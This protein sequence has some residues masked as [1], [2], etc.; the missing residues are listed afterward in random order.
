[1]RTRYFLVLFCLLLPFGGW[2]QSE[3]TLAGTVQTESGTALAGATVLLKGSTLGGST[4]QEGR[5]IVKVP[6]FPAVVLVSFVG[7]QT[8]E[9][10]LNQPDNNL[11]V[12][13][14][15]TSALNQIVV[16]ASREAETIGRAPATVEKVDQRQLGQVPD[17]DLVAGLARFKGLDL[18]SSSMLAA[19]F[20][21]RGFNSPKSERVIQLADY[22]DTQLPSLGINFGNLNGL[23][24][25][26]VASVEIL[27]GP[28]SALYGANA[29]NGVLITNSRDALTDPGLTVRL[30]GGSRNLL[31]GQLRYA[32][33][34]G[35][36]LAFKI[37]GG[38]FQA[39]DFLPDNQQATSTLI[40]PDNNPAG[41]N[42]GFDAVNRYG[43]LGNQFT[44]APLVPGGPPNRLAGKTVF[45]PGYSETELVAGDNKA[46]SLKIMPSL[47]YQLSNS[48]KATLDYR[49]ASTT[50]TYQAGSRYRFLNS[51]IQQQRLR[52]EG[53]GWFL[54]AFSTQD[55]SG[56]RDPS[57]DGSYNLGFLGAFLQ[58]QIVPNFFVPVNPNQPTGPTRP[59][60]YAER[61]FG[62]YQAVYNATFNG[63]NGGD[64]EAAA[65]AARNAA[66]IGAPFLQP[67]TESFNQARD[68]IIHD[69]TPG[70]GA[71][72]II[73]SILNEGSGQYNFKSD[74]ADL[75]VG[76]AYR[77]Y[78][79]GSDGS[80]FS[81]SPTSDRIR[82]Y[83]YGVYAQVNKALFDDHLRVSA[84]GRLDQFQNFG[85]AFSPRFSAVYTAGAD[86]QHNI[87]ASFSQAFRAPT[88]DQ[89]Y[90]R[91]DVGR[92]ILLGNV[93]QGFE[94][95]R[96]T[97]RRELPG[98][99][100]PGREADLKAFEFSSGKL[101]L[102]RVS[103]GELGYRAQLTS[104][105][106]VDFDYY[107]SVFNDFIG[108]QNFIGNI[109]GSRPTAAGP[110]GNP[111]TGQ[112]ARGASVRFGSPVLANGDANPT[113]VIQI[114][115]NVD[116]TVR[117]QGAGLT[118]GYVVSEG[119]TLSGNYSFNEL[120]TTDFKAE[121]FSFF[122]TPRHKFNLGF[123]GLALAR[124]LSY[125]V[126]YR[127]ADSFTYESTFAT[128]T[129]P[130][131]QTLDA[132]LGYTLKALRT[133]LQAGIN[134]AFDAQNL[135][136]YGAPQLGRVGYFGL[137]FNL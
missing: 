131:A 79:L 4:N 101:R 67:G 71:R 64:A 73:R 34:L 133:T 77:Q 3:P 5:F 56:S 136:V 87:R 33:K 24:V 61:Y 96:T 110:G 90:I 43:D 42:F 85:S 48:V 47:T 119:L 53:N 18:S 6:S 62:T 29:F 38:I 112:I 84:A 83:E 68:R 32:V 94:G 27:H 25:L 108:T 35:E 1:M 72:L 118:L 9:L 109:D 80:L 40:E 115:T 89:Q 76:G 95:Y 36:R 120:I 13:M 113:R 127:W 116:Q 21:T 2:A 106:F 91:L 23:P 134:N 60:T 99:L 58:T 44:A 20:S 46:R 65:L 8:L 93:G 98:I 12:I 17:P 114:S 39:N 63:P 50:S 7:Y 92:A 41:S 128:G 45:L 104:K 126:N 52:L 66:N 135:Q 15:P 117:S 70:R 103:S 121:T 37:A 19:S 30:R 111:A 28:A 55:Y 137:L 129:V 125:N 78:L 51:G 122:N 97:L 100:A 22:L 130:V 123:D 59:G 88:Q 75:V 81:D 132:Q 11:E 86:K 124:R 105:L 102:E 82:N 74:I 31:D 54:R 10:T 69:P 49:Y 26:D 14:R 107:Y 57:T 16:A